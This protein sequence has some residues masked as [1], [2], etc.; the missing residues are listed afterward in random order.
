MRLCVNLNIVK[1]YTR[2]HVVVTR[3]YAV[4]AAATFVCTV[5][6]AC[7]N[8]QDDRR[9]YFRSGRPS[10]RR[11]RSVCGLCGASCN[12]QRRR[13][14]AN[15]DGGHCRTIRLARA[16]RDNY[17]GWLYCIYYYSMVSSNN[18]RQACVCVNCEGS[19]IFDAQNKKNFFRFHNVKITYCVCETNRVK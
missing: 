19:E 16:L 17:T 7:H 12:D 14:A 8:I 15:E 3:P 4:C 13:A 6:R 2:V 11:D 5:V 1:N 18:S 9:R 10:N